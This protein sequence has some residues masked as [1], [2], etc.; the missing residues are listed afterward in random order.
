L[1][2]QNLESANIH[3]EEQ[4]NSSNRDILTLSTQLSKMQIEE[5]KNREAKQKEQENNDAY[6]QKIL[7]LELALQRAENTHKI[8]M[9]EM[10]NK[11][12]LSARLN[13]NSATQLANQALAKKDAQ[14][15]TLENSLK[16]TNSALQAAKE[17][18]IKTIE[19]HQSRI[20]HLQEKYLNDAKKESADLVDKVEK[21]LLEEKSIEIQSLTAKFEQDIQSLKSSFDQELRNA[22]RKA[23]TAAE[24]LCLDLETSWKNKVETLEREKKNLEVWVL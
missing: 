16:A 6:E 1:T 17:E 18:R 2:I 3:L 22:S 7:A 21:R 24:N 8:E 5:E 9:E 13:D 14:L 15:R 23:A 11:S 4:L 19:A 10:K 20:K 12:E